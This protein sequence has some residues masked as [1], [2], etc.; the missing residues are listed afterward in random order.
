MKVIVT[1]KDE[2]SS[3]AGVPFVKLYYVAE[4]GECGEVFTSK[5]NYDKFGFSSKKVLES[6]DLS[7]M[8]KSLESANVEF[9]SQGKV[10]AL[11]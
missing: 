5:E 11:S 10:V 3:K 1:K 8:F 6:A 7:E 9:N 2:F 4:N